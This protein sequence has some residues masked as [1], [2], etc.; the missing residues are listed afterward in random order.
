MLLT[1]RN[2]QV[3]HFLSDAAAIAQS[4]TL[5]QSVAWNISGIAF[6]IGNEFCYCYPVLYFFLVDA[7]ETGYRVPASDRAIKEA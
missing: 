1:V 6:K 3:V 5:P 4:E 7:F 2:D